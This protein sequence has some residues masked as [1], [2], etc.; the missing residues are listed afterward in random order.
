MRKLHI[1]VAVL[2]LLSV[3]VVPSALAATPTQITY[4]ASKVLMRGYFPRGVNASVFISRR[5]SVR[6]QT[7]VYADCAGLIP[8]P[9]YGLW[10]FGRK[11][12][13]RYDCSAPLNA[14]VKSPSFLP[15][16]LPFPGPDYSLYYRKLRAQAVELACHM[17]R[18]DVGRTKTPEAFKFH[19]PC[20]HH[21][22]SVGSDVSHTT[23][24]YR[25]P[26]LSAQGPGRRM[27]SVTLSADGHLMAQWCDP[28][29]PPVNL[30]SVRM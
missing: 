17:V 5:Y 19:L 14:T 20:A 9:R 18:K 22:R 29:R 15:P 30:S 16:I 26:F 1:A 4:N 13:E 28:D 11:N 3:F 25:C 2:S 6:N 24:S 8:Q 12:I 21:M 7:Q 10:R 27:R 23:L